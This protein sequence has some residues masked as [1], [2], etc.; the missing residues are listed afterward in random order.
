M[1]YQEFAPPP[2]LRPSVDR[3]W[4]LETGDREEAVDP[5][6]PDGHPEIILHCAEPFG[7]LDADGAV[8]VQ[9]RVLFAGQLNH[10]VRVV[11]RGHARVVGARLH[12]FAGPAFVAGSQHPHAD[13]VADLHTLHPALADALAA[14][15]SADGPLPDEVARFADVLLAFA[16]PLTEPAVERAVACAL[17]AFGM[18][19][20]DAMARAAHVGER[21]LERLFRHHVGVTP[22]TWLRSIR[23]QEVLRTIREG[24][25]PQWAEIAQQHGFYDQAHFVRDFKLFTG[26]AP[27]VFRVTDESLTAVF[28]A[29]R[30]ERTPDDGKDVGFFQDRRGDGP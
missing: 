24:E 22:K 27:S 4:V 2:A 13:R 17:G 6:L 30:R 11:P 28:S 19:R 3:L 20:V 21:H 18:V 8:R 9:A 29:V 1:S 14:G 16:A 10:A 25:R 23:F 7:E 12:A 26:Q 15:R 5:I